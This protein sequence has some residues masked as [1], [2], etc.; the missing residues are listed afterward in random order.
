MFCNSRNRWD[1]F[2]SCSSDDVQ[3]QRQHCLSQWLDTCML[4]PLT[5]AH[6]IFHRLSIY[7]KQRFCICICKSR[8]TIIQG[9]TVAALSSPS[10]GHMFHPVNVYYLSLMCP[11][12]KPHDATLSKAIYLVIK[13]TSNTVY[14]QLLTQ[15]TLISHREKTLAVFIFQSQVSGCF[16]SPQRCS[17]PH[18]GRNCF[19]LFNLHLSPHLLIC[20]LDLKTL[21]KNPERFYIS[22]QKQVIL[23]RRK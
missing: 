10:I 1:L 8:N 12:K 18:W 11:S 9:A 13:A 15:L 19:L 4:H 6:T 17:S 21:K 16:T 20:Q 23:R 5:Q 14:I 3:L 22:Q 2:S 7:E